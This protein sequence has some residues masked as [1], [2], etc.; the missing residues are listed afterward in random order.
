MI[1]APKFKLLKKDEGEHKKY[2]VCS[3]FVELFVVVI[4][5]CAGVMSLSKLL[6]KAPSIRWIDGE[7]P[8]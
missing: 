6:V 4:A 8:L 7:L 5:V 1:L 2:V 3:Y